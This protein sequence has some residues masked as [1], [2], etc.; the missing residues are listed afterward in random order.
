MAERP[1]DRGEPDLVP[2]TP[3]ARRAQ[4]LIG[5]AILALVGSGF[6]Y[7]RPSPAVSSPP[8]SALPAPQPTLDRMQ[9]TSPQKGWVVVQDTGLSHST[10]FRTEDGG[11][12]W[13]RLRS[14]DNGFFVVSFVDSRF[15]L[16]QIL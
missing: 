7:L 11:A 13:Q 4:L 2:V 1:Q 8:V 15:G 6:V 10:L 3:R 5:V 16:L 14:T 12:H 9:W